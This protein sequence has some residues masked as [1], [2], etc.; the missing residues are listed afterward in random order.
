M[1]FAS[2]AALGL[3]VAIHT[4]SS[5]RLKPESHKDD[6]AI[7]STA[8]ASH[9]THHGHTCSHHH[10]P[11][12]D[13][14]SAHH[15]RPLPQPGLLW[16]TDLTD[17]A[18]M[19]LTG[20]MPSPVDYRPNTRQSIT[21]ENGTRIHID[22]QQRH[23]HNDGTIAINGTVAGKTQ[24]RL[25]M[26]WNS[27]DDFF[28]GQIEFDNH[29]VA[30]EITRDAQ[31]THHITRR[32]ITELV[33]AEIDTTTGAVRYGLPQLPAHEAGGVDDSEAAHAEGP[34]LVPALNSYPAASACIYL[35]FDGEQVTGT[36]WGSNI[37]AA[38]TGYS[39]SKITDIWKRVA[40][41][42]EPFNLNVT[43]DESVYLSAPATRRIRCIIT[44]S[45]E[46][47][48]SNSA[49]GVAKYNSFVWS[50]DTPCW[51]FS[52][53]LANGSKYIAEA[54][55]HEAGHT[56]GLSHDGKSGTTYY[57]G[58]G[59]GAVSW[60]PIMGSGYFKS[61]TQWSK[62]EY[63]SAT[64][65][66]DDLSIIASATNGFG[67]RSDDHNNQD[68]SATTLAADSSNQ[69]ASSGTI[70]RQ[71]DTDVFSM[72]SGAGTLTL[73]ITP[74]NSYGNL[75]IQADLFD[76]SGNLVTSINPATQLN[77]NISTSVSAGTY[78]LHVRSTG[79][80]SANTGFTDYASLGAYTVT[81]EVAAAAVPTPFELTMASLPE[82][83]RNPSDDPDGDGIS[84]LTEHALGTDPASPE[85][86]HH[87]SSVSPNGSSGVEFLIDL[88]ADIPSDV[89]YTVEASCTLDSTDWTSIAS[90]DTAGQWSGSVTE[91]S[92]PSG[93]RRFRVTENPS[94]PWT[95]RFIRIHIEL[96]L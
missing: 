37:N 11:D 36:S 48:G 22:V 8:A 86:S 34:S 40:A 15:S 53:N 58:H 6:D 1:I 4:Q 18:S 91:E 39:A 32:S 90:R 26:Q 59:S 44:P 54:C 14:R 13:A 25:H 73:A 79:Y 70:E 83:Q 96:A 57:A 28:L 42:F 78:F 45:N 5:N 71:D 66:Q 56:F 87:F 20:V 24:G 72:E 84:N 50:G 61:V 80:G 10:S 65:T 33:C 92:G 55:S 75:D 51:V 95:C 30:Y 88:P 68:S 12:N 19:E 31:G 52:D 21:I 89:L 38:A 2:T 3:A 77:A 85:T 62:G 74:A 17:P 81:G 46:W 63:S 41:D 64:N 16:E 94:E 43:T 35:D 69:I 27:Q 82:N 29:P 93:T 76:A 7:K 60:A 67:Y 49:G 47:Y 23:T 9:H